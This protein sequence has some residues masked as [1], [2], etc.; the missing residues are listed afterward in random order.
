MRP[1]LRNRRLG[2]VDSGHVIASFKR[3]CSRRQSFRETLTVQ[4][5]LDGFV[6]LFLVDGFRAEHI[7]SVSVLG[8]ADESVLCSPLHLAGMVV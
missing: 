8:D 1:A 3:S 5:V 7:G 6:Q 2:L 4:C